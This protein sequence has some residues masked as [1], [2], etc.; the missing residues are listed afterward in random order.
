MFSPVSCR[1]KK[2]V[3]EGISQQLSRVALYTTLF[4]SDFT[5]VSSLS[6]DKL[7]DIFTQCVDIMAFLL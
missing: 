7:I 2:D 3:W 4:Q 1:F 5:A 6:T